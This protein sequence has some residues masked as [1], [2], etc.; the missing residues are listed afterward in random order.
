MTCALI[1]LFHSNFLAAT[2]L[3]PQSAEQTKEYIPLKYRSTAKGP[4]NSSMTSW[5]LLIRKQVTKFPHEGS[6]RHWN[7]SSRRGACCKLQRSSSKG[8]DTEQKKTSWRHVTSALS[9]RIHW[10]TTFYQFLSSSFSQ[11]TG[12]FILRLNP[13]FVISSRWSAK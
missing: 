3:Y 5:F 1:L 10:I 11:N 8:G 7:W 4:L 13:S 2:V 6:E 9:E 12:F